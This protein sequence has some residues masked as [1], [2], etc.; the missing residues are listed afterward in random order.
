MAHFFVMVAA[1]G[2]KS[3]LKTLHV[4]YITSFLEGDEN[5]SVFGMQHG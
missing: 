4:A 2:V 1:S 5:L 3:C